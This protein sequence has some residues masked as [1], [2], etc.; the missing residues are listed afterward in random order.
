MLA[1]NLVFESAWKQFTGGDASALQRLSP[2]VLR[3]WKR[4]RGLNLDPNTVATTGADTARLQL[5]EG[6]Y[7]PLRDAARPVMERLFEFVSKTGFQVVLSD[8]AGYL[9][10]SIGDEEIMMRTCEVGLCPGGDWSEA[11]KGTNAI[12]TAIEER[13]PV[14]IFGA[15]HYCRP[16]QFLVC[17]AAPIYD[18]DGRMVGVLDL[19]GDFE[20]CN[21]HSLGM[22][23]A[24]V[25]AIETN[26]RLMRLTGN[27][28]S[29]YRY[30]S[31]LLESMSDGMVSID[32]R[33]IVTDCNSKA[34][35]IFGLD[36]QQS[37]GRPLVDLIQ[38]DTPLLK[39]IETG[40]PYMDREIYYPRYNKTLRSSASLIRD[41]LGNILGAI[42]TF[43]EI[44]PT[45]SQLPARRMALSA[46]VHT[47]DE[48]QGSS[49]AILHLKERIRLAAKSSSTVLITGESGTGKELVARVLHSQSSRAAGPFVAINCAAMPESLIESELFGYEDGAFT[50]AR[51]GGRPGKFEMANGGTLFLDEIGDMPASAQIKLLRVLQERRV[52]RIGES[53]ERPVDIRVVAATHRNL[54]Q[55]V[56]SGA[57]R[58]DLYYRLNVLSL[59]LPAMR[60]RLADLPSLAIQLL[61]RICQRMAIAPRKIDMQS[62]AALQQQSWPGNVR[63]LENTL[64]RAV[65]WAGDETVLRLEHFDLKPVM[66]AEPVRTEPRKGSGRLEECE[67]HSIEAAIS[68]H[69]GN[70]LRAAASLGI[71]RNTIYRKLRSY[72]L[73]GTQA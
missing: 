67:R 40:Q 19:S 7:K 8:E 28:Y 70:I 30:S 24:A 51:R 49:P 73:Q 15:Q 9:I 22:V 44:A 52:T 36:R 66:I 32:N 69:D 38:C 56:V 43:H 50:G 2:E 14:Q 55:E 61:E 31:I 53:Q 16:N 48:I 3:S 57:F 18:P 65:N 25:G 68:A 37:K 45:G 26:L 41:D 64:E 17:S 54:E 20:R 12:G 62:I 63:Q 6:I 11:A 39:V 71:S 46:P 4:C 59:H 58:H 21:D 60:E 33:G 34:S 10:D 1:S 5:R 42:A 47:L 72:R 23:V 13:K 29:A 35:R 27:L